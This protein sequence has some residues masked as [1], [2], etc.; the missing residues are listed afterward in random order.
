MGSLY[1]SESK[2]NAKR[3]GAVIVFT[4]EATFRQ[5]PTLHATWSRRGCQPKIPT[6]GER[7]SQK[8][9][10][11]VRLETAE[12]T[13][14]HHQENFQWETYLAFLDQVVLPAFCRRGRRIYLI[15]DNA[16]YHKKAEIYDWFSAN[17]KRLEVF[18]LPPYWPELNAAERVWH[19][20]RVKVTH[21]RF[22]ESSESHCEALVKTFEEV[23]KQPHHI[24]GL[25]APFR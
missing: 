7:N 12:F 18:N 2:K 4:D 10:G 13:Y 6:R 15:Q 5:T 11:A 24:D 19:Y 23:R 9:F 8:I 3:E 1:L 25:I 16:G 21:N 22:F 20:T 17:R 14:L